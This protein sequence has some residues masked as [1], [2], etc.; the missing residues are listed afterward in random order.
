[1]KGISFTFLS[2]FLFCASARSQV[3]Q[4]PALQPDTVPIYRTTVI[5]RT[6]Q[7]IN[8]GHRSEPTKIDFQGPFWLPLVT[9]KPRYRRSAARPLSMQNS[10]TSTSPEGSAP[11][12]SLTFYGLLLRK[13]AR[14]TW[15]KWCRVPPIKPSCM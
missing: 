13:D 3:P 1:M 4:V 5:G 15:G 7:A 14:S 9:A 2:L 11:S 12:T 10:I 6:I 8:Y